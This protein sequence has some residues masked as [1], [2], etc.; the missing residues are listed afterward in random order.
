VTSGYGG[1]GGG[2]GGAECYKCGKVGHI[3]RQCT[4]GGGVGG[5]YNPPQGGS[6]GGQTCYS[7]GGYGAVPNLSFIFC[8]YIYA[9]ARMAL[10]VANL[11]LGHL[12][13]DCTQGQKCY[14][15]G[16]IGHLSRECP[17]EQDRVCYK[18]VSDPPM[19]NPSRI[20]PINRCKQPGH[21]MASCPEAQAA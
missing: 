15:C 4:A 21:V 19:F 18:F 11:S 7:C 2:A 17:S 1:G 3:A 12:S 9:I 8:F 13:R 5:G 6:R 20:D 10:N 14:N 16:Q